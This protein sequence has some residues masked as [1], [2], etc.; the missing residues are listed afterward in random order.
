MRRPLNLKHLLAL[1]ISLLMCATIALIAMT[2]GRSG[3]RRV[4]VEIG[5]SLKL[6]ADQMQDKLDRTLFERYREIAT[7]A[8]LFRTLAVADRPDAVKLWLSELQQTYPDY[9]WIGFTR[10]NGIVARATNGVLE[11]TDMSQRAWFISGL[12]EPT[13][14]DVH[15][16]E[17]L[18]QLVQRHA[19]AQPKFLDISAPV[20]AATGETIGVLGAQIDWSWAEEVRDSLFGNAPE[21]KGEQV[22][23]LT[24]TGVV[25]LGPQ[26]LTGKKLELESVRQAMTGANKFAIEQWPDGG[27]YVTGYAK[28]NGYR[29]F[30]GL[31]WIVLV[32]QNAD[33]ALAPAIKLQRQTLVLSLG[34]AA[35]AAIAAWFLS[36]RISA[37][38]LRLT[39]AADALREGNPVGIP[40]VRDY[41]EV[42]SLS[43]SL[44]TLVSELKHRQSALEALNESLETQVE[45]RTSDLAGRNAALDLAL[46]QAEEATAVKSRFLAAASHDLRQPLH[47]M[48]LFTR[49]LS[50][51][52]S[53]P[54]APQLVAQLEGSLSSLKGIFDVL[55]NVSRLDA[56]LIQPN[57]ERVS[58]VELLER[59]T[60]GFR[61][62][63]EGRGLKFKT[64][65]LDV[66]IMTDPALLETILRNLVSNAL[67]F[68]RSGGVLLA[69][70]CHSEG[71]LFEV[72][73][74]GPAS[75]R[76]A[77]AG[78]TKNSSDRRN[79][80]AV[81]TT[82]WAWGSRS[83]GAML[84]CWV[85]D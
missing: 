32:R 42:E 4:E 62:E 27:R 41:A 38:L 18:A 78:S 14:G 47:A 55:L 37:P 82:D 3:V 60:V 24:E 65:S 36:G 46:A 45:Q 22:L 48:A 8:R 21:G 76:I 51:R 12:K 7:A 80:Q 66:L 52:V 79:R 63:A 10:R 49:A 23:V 59:L 6:L 56:G 30:A 85:S 73:D 19:A 69:V 25:L 17:N 16:D 61:A 77:K 11:G 83:S 67:K 84:N 34:L 43:R 26:E 5:S 53:G 13:V 74:T 50:R 15:A 29:N 31:G 58:A 20:V 44:A 70:R 81:P 64:H 33:E 72:Y 54:E 28:S 75:R 68:T 39:H 9:A 2:V 40:E 35:L 71:V 1:S 57:V